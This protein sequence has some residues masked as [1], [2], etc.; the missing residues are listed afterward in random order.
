MLNKTTYHSNIYTYPIFKAVQDMLKDIKN[1]KE[2]C[3]DF[4]EN[5]KIK[6][7]NGEL[8]HFILKKRDSS[9]VDLKGFKKSQNNKW[10][11]TQNSYNLKYKSILSCKQL[12]NQD[13]ALI[14]KEGIFIYT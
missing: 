5:N 7:T 8:F 4:P 14:T 11:K 9:C 1:R 6:L 3:C 2:V 13:L 12:R 10:E